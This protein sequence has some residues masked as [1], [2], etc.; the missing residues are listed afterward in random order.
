MALGE[1]YKG[2]HIV[3]GSYVT[4]SMKSSGWVPSIRVST[5]PKG[6]GFSVKMPGPLET[7]DTRE[8]A[9]QRGLEVAKAWID[10]KDTG[11]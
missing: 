10:A 4:G 2:W 3:V 11:G 9:E 1:T 8:A 7:F 5:V 6:E